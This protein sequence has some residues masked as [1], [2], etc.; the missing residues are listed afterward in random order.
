MDLFASPCRLDPNLRSLLDEVASYL[1][2]W[3]AN[4]S[5][6]SP[7]PEFVNCPD[8]APLSKGI[9]R[10]ELLNDL[11][12]IIDGS[13]QPS[14]P[15]ALAHLD[16]PPLT[17]S[18]VGDLVSAG[19]NNNL[20][21][22]ELSPSLSV[23]ERNLCKWMAT[24][25]GMPETSGG[26]AASGGSLSNLMA[27]VLARHKSNL[28]FD[29]KIAII[30]N[31]DA[32][33]SITR[34]LKIMGLPS[35]VFFAIKPNNNGEI[36]ISEINKCLVKIKSKGLKCLAIIAT[37]G[38]T[39]SGD[40]DPIE[41][42]AQICSSNKIWLHVDASIGG[43]FG[44][45]NSTKDLLKGISLADSVTVNPQKVL[46]ITKTSSLLLVSDINNLYNCFSTGFPY[47]D[48]SNQFEFQGGELG[49]QGSRSP[50]ILKLWL[51]LRQ[52]GINGITSVLENSIARKKYF[53]EQLDSTTF[54]IKTGPLHLTSFSP[55]NLSNDEAAIWANKTKHLLLQN[56]FMLSRPFYNKRYYLKAVF[57][58]PHTQSSHIDILSKIINKSVKV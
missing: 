32:H 3:Y 15:G 1:C 28:S 34:A 46:G 33:V 5:N 10:D 50:E 14:S 43:V 17:A 29:T 45:S 24:A 25:L 30:A 55:K 9:S 42:I 22:K 2:E 41:D 57:G 39:F 4:A 52:L 40:I 47:L 6:S 11:Q 44:L 21:A 26:V 16:P 35:N 58:N 53:L 36:L 38:T 7:L 48:P 31:S 49:I 20:L 51:G 56:K 27:L 37:A 23:L 8:V 54:N 13:Y 12:K 18:I 19:L